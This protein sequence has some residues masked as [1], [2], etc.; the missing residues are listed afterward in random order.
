MREIDLPANAARRLPLASQLAMFLQLLWRPGMLPIVALRVPHIVVLVIA[1]HIITFEI[2]LVMSAVFA[3]LS[4]PFPTM[5]AYLLN[6]VTPLLPCWLYGGIVLGLILLGTFYFVPPRSTRAD[7]CVL[8]AIL[9]APMSLAPVL[10]VWA[11]LAMLAQVHDPSFGLGAGKPE[12]VYSPF[13]ALG[14]SCFW[15]PA[16]LIASIVHITWAY[17]RLMKTDAEPGWPYCAHCGYSL[18]GLDHRRCPEC[19]EEG[20]P[21]SPERPS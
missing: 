9:F 6:A 13:I 12:W 4:E 15:L 16:M 1:V 3:G 2:N 8:R 20:I 5:K 7:D 19:G 10:L 17:G 11:P 14:G 18:A 21:I